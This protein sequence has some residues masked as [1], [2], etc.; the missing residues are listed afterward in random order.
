MLTRRQTFSVFA[1]ATAALALP[2]SARA[3][4]QA[5]EFRIGWQKGGVFALAK[6]SGAIESR[7]APRG[8][9]VSWA[10]FTS[11]PPLLEALGPMR[12]IS[13]PLGTCRPCLRRRRAGTWFMSPLQRAALKARPF[14]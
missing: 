11:G 12:L 2:G 10:E 13:A 7:L 1:G 6:T 9:S 5:T 8:I 14:L 4:D 3:L